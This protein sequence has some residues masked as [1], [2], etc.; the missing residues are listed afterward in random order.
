MLV[1]LVIDSW[2]GCQLYLTEDQTFITAERRACNEDNM[3]LVLPAECALPIHYNYNTLTLP[4][5]TFVCEQITYTREGIFRY[6]A[7]V[8]TILGKLSR[9]TDR[10]DPTG[11]LC[12]AAAD[13]S[14]M[15]PMSL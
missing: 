5:F 9:L 2:P 7:S 15:S 13:K 3:G 10:A 12:D 6:L 11:C 8:K 1:V 4:K 14:I